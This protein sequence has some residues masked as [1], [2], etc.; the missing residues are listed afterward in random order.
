MSSAR[1]ISNHQ[2]RLLGQGDPMHINFVRSERA[3]LRPEETGRLGRGADENVDIHVWD[4]FEIQPPPLRANE[5][6]GAVRRVTSGAPR[7]IL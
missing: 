5:I 4:E 6:G 7:Q 3:Q 1:S 2:A